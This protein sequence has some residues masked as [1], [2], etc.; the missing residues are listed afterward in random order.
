MAKFTKL[1]KKFPPSN[2]I[3]WSKRKAFAVLAN[4]RQ[5]QREFDPVESPELELLTEDGSN[6]IR[7]ETSS[8]ASP[9]Y[10]TTE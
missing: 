3:H 9:E 2:R 5:W 8:S 4:R 6:Y 10:I 1:F 7:T